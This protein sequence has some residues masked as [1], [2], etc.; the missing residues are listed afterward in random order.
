MGSSS[1]ATTNP[2]D[3]RVRLMASTS[4][5][6]TNHIQVGVLAGLPPQ[7]RINPPS[8]VQPDF[9]TRLLQ[10]LHQF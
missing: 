6:A 10:G 5:R 3:E 7:Q 9:S 4:A 1:S 2:L 8:S